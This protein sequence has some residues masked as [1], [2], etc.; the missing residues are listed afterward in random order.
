MEDDKKTALF[1]KARE[2]MRRARFLLAALPMK[3]GGRKKC[4]VLLDDI[5]A[6]ITRAGAHLQSDDIDRDAKPDNDGEAES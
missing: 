2:H 1:N 3:D 6:V 4:G 5:D